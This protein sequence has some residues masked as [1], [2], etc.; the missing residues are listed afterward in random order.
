MPQYRSPFPRLF[1]TLFP[2][3]LCFGPLLSHHCSRLGRS[4]KRCPKASTCLSVSALP[5]LP[6]QSSSP[7][8]NIEA[9]YI[10]LRYPFSQPLASKT[11]PP[12]QPDPLRTHTHTHSPSS[13]PSPPRLP[14][15]PSLS[16]PQHKTP[17]QSISTS[18]P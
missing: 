10:P 6:A 17:R 11:P 8:M 16:I 2:A 5:F 3:C 18:Q 7:K 12:V 4:T 9:S 15:L 14:S 1:L 13:I